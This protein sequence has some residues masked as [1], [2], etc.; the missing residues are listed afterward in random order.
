MDGSKRNNKSKEF[1]INQ[2]IHI[3]STS[4]LPKNRKLLKGVLIFLILSIVSI[5]CMLGFFGYPNF[6]VECIN[7]VSHKWTADLNTYLNKNL[8]VTNLLIISSSLFI[9]LI[10]VCVS[11]T[12]TMRSNSWRFI[13]ALLIF[14]LFRSI[15][16]NVFHMRYPD[17]FIWNYPGLPSLAVS[18]FITNDFF[19]SGHVGL[20]II[21][22]CEFIKH[23]NYKMALFSIFSCVFEFVVMIII[24]GHY[25]IDLIFGVITAH[26]IFILVDKYI[27]F[28][29]ETCLSLKE[30]HDHLQIKKNYQEGDFPKNS[31]DDDSKKN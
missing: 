26:Y 15:I 6:D 17:G 18:Y 5:N 12:W 31:T 1:K 7:D 9:D 24:R 8:F 16:Q 20:P 3:K 28:I 27:Y 25:I 10:L 4:I 2:D 29:D 30:D 23:K 22:A 19:F 21:V 11:I 14:Y 13:M